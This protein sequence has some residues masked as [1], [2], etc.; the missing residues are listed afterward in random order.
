MNT[1][2]PVQL[3]I[4]PYRLMVRGDFIASRN[5]IRNNNNKNNN[6]VLFTDVIIVFQ[7]GFI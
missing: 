5:S 3:S 1:I 7:S 2:V 4:Q 6:N